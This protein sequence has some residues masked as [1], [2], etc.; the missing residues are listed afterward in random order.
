MLSIGDVGLSPAILGYKT[1]FYRFLIEKSKGG[2]V[3][4]EISVD[5]TLNTDL[6]NP[7]SKL[8]Y[9]RRNKSLKAHK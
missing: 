6:I 2:L 9:L 1:L 4:N 7:H 3:S 5:L 8:L